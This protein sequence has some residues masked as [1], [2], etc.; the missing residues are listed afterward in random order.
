[1]VQVSHNKHLK[2]VNDYARAAAIANLVYVNDKDPGIERVKRGK[3]FTYLLQQKKITDKNELERIKKLAIP[4]AWTRVWI[5]QKPNGHIQATGF[6][7]R[8]RKQ[9]RYHPLWNLL[10]NETKFHKLLEFGKV[11]PLLRLQVEKDLAQ[12][13]LNAK[14][15]IALVISLMERTYIR[16]GNS[17]Y[18]KANGSHGLTTLKDKHV[19]VEEDKISFSF[20]GKR[21]IHH[22]I[23]LNH[24]RLAKVIKQCRDIPGKELFQYY[25]AGNQR[26]SIDSGMV[27]AYIHEATGDIFTAKDFRTWAGCL[28][29][30]MAFKNMNMP[31]NAGSLK[32][33]INEAL[34][35]VS[36]HLGNTRLVCKKYYVHPGII[37][38]YEENKLEKHLKELEDIEVSDG[39]TSLTKE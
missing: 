25:D 13:E 11:L 27:N 20:N 39:V 10:R 30:L 8:S 15:V 29:L 5:C 33:N 6:D 2:L 21:N 16:I 3:Y 17:S 38:L 19:N 36:I 34:D 31:E 9:Y 24:K 35:Y 12:K 1:M 7:I 22:D 18:E 26:N 28:H 23:S 32:K 37:R 4:P 14:K